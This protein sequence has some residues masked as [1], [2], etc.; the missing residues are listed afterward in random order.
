MSNFVKVAQ[1]A[2]IPDQSTMCVEVEG[3]S[4]ALFNLGGEIYAI[5]DT[6]THK[7]GPL[8]EG[9][10]DGEEVECPWHGARFN[11]KSGAVMLDPADEKVTTYPVRI[12]GDDIEVEVL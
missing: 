4:I 8:S 7:G 3:R 5:D 12:T 2:E 11:I 9:I 6:C 10:I 1:T